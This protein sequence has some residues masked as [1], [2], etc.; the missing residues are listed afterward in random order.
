MELAPD[1]TKP[2]YLMLRSTYNRFINFLSTQLIS[3]AAQRP[4]AGDYVVTAEGAI[5]GVMVDDQLA[6]VL[7]DTDFA[8]GA[9]AI[10]LGTPRDFARDALQL[11]KTLK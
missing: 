10:S 2:G 5:V 8:A 6:Y 1:L 4:E 11:R 9:R 3:T 7:S